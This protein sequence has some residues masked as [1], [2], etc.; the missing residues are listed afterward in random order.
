[1]RREKTSCQSKK[2]KKSELLQQVMGPLPATR[3]TPAR[4]FERCG[5]G[6]CGPINTYL[7]NRGKPPTKSYLAVFVC[8]VTKAVDIEV[9]SDLSTNAFLNA[10]KRMNGRRKIPCD[11]FD[12]ATMLPNC[13]R[14]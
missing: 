6:P 13:W 9:V 11:I 4:P 7:R 5:I 14:I 10:L 8:L 12:N 1:M 3:A 2:K